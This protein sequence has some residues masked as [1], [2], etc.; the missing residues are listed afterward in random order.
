MATFNPDVKPDNVRDPNYTKATDSISQPKSDQS[1]AILAQTVGGAI[2]GIAGI[3]DGV[4][5][6]IIKDDVYNRVDKERQ[7]F[8]DALTNTNNFGDPRGPQVAQNTGQPVDILASDNQPSVPNSISNGIA[9]AGN[10]Q[11]ALNGNKISE[12][13][14]Y[15]RLGDIAKSLRSSYPGYR[16]YIDQEISKITGVNPANAYISSII[17]DLNRKNSTAGDEAKFWRNKIVDSGYPGSDK[18]LEYYERTGDHNKVMQFLSD[19]NGIRSTLQLKKAAF[20]AQTNDQTDK[21]NKARDFAQTA[22]NT[23]ATTFFYNTQKYANGDMSPSDIS[24][25]LTD[26]SL[27]PQK[28]NDQAYQGLSERYAALQVQATNQTMKQ[29]YMRPKMQDGTYGKSVADVLG[30]DETRKIV[31]NSIGALFKST[32]DFIA[33]KQFGPA[34]TNQNQAAAAVNNKTM[35]VLADPTVGGTVGTLAVM[36]KLAPNIAP[37]LTGKVLGQGLDQQL[38]TLTIQQGAQA[39][40]QTGGRYQ[41]IDG[42]VYSFRQSMEELEQVA[43]SQGVL[44][45]GQAPKNLLEVKRVITDPSSS[46]E[47]V[48]NVVNYLYDPKVNKGSLDKIMDDYYDPT[49]REVVKGRS[50]AFADLTAPDITSSIKKSGQE[51]W[52]KY[53]QWAKDEFASQ[54]GEKVRDLNDIQREGKFNVSWNSETKQLDI[55]NRNGTPLQ[56]LQATDLNMSYRTINNLNKGLGNMANLAKEEGT[57]VDAYIFKTLRDNGYAPDKMVDGIPSQIM[58]ALIVGNGGKVRTGADIPVSK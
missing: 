13:T 29:L 35:M 49:R 37:L 4:V 53:T 27:N 50:S 25:K 41:G 11:A 32:R 26:L 34:Y 23:A 42:K 12:T 40:A 52:K 58:R 3:A 8:S 33:D 19:N 21:L 55:V 18:V 7:D 30:P 36:N 43:S 56:G 9:K 38:S 5:K 57:S 10:V 6:G 44:I 24:D 17:Q 48:R 14:Y 22:A 47:A 1:G 46:P 16:E 2:E 51:N 20:E 31:E 45:S 39:V 54:L 28:A 15:Q